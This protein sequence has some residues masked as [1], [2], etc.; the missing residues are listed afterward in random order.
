MPKLISESLD[1]FLFEGIKD[2][3]ITVA[4]KA[5]KDKSPEFQKLLSILDKDRGLMILFTKWLLGIP[6][7]PK[8][9]GRTV[10]QALFNR[11]RPVPIQEL[12]HLYNQ[13][14]EFGLQNFK[15][16][17]NEFKNAE[18]FGDYITEKHGDKKV[19]DILNITTHNEHTGKPIGIPARIKQMI[20]NNEK[21]YNLFRMNLDYAKDLA[22]FTARH[23][24][25]S[26]TLDKLFGDISTYLSNI[27]E[28]FSRKATISKINEFH[29][30]AKI[31]DVPDAPHLLLMF[32]ED[33]TACVNLGSQEWCIAQ[34]EGFGFS[35]EEEATSKKNINKI[36]KPTSMALNYFDNTYKL[37]GVNK[38]YFLYDFS[39]SAGDI[40]RKICFIVKPN[41]EDKNK[42]DVVSAWNAKDGRIDNPE[43]FVLKNFPELN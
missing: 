36:K 13:A 41:K 40:L 8:T 28:N 32:I 23:G 37:S 1:N 17:F 15:K 43:A 20:L 18:E 6:T 31:I 14:K 30:N 24:A 22:D 4:K 27:E 35:H 7:G 33:V 12:E 39:R 19:K 21:L 5:K 29:L 34:A 11:V 3:A 16:N 9:P 2:D 38:C 26:N 42:G 10:Q 25:R